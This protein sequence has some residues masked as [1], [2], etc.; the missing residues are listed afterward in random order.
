MA[1]HHHAAA[2]QFIQT[3]CML[4]RVKECLSWYQKYNSVVE[5]PLATICMSVHMY[6]YITRKLCT[7]A[8]A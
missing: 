1:I 3:V 6:I 2:W 8:T 7:C 4:Y 5:V